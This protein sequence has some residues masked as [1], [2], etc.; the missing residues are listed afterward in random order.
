MWPELC[1]IV[2]KAVFHEKLLRDL[3]QM[4]QALINLEYQRYDVTA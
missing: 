4:G 1:A 2:I 3:K